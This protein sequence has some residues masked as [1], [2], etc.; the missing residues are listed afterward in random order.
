MDFTQL[1]KD[2]P[3]TERR[4]PHNFTDKEW[5]LRDRYIDELEKKYP[6]IPTMMLQ[7]LV[8]NTLR[9]SSEELDEIIESKKWEEPTEATKSRRKG[10]LWTEGC[11]ITDEEGNKIIENKEE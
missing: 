4:N 6:T 5:V 9:K 8:E 1:E 2:C 11:Y 10:G 3:R 7:L